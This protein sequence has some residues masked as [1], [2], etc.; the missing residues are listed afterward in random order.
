MTP[1]LH[2]SVV[3]TTTDSGMVLLHQDSGRYYELNPTG[4][5]I[6]QSLAD[7]TDPVQELM[8]RT[9]VSQDRAAQDV[10][11][12]LQSLHSRGLVVQR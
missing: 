1:Q 3:A 5:T 4:A 6:V 7:G 10:S 11:T 12:F 9:S 8:R 2:P